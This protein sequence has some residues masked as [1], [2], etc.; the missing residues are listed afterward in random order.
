MR[1]LSLAAL[2]ALALSLPGY[3]ASALTLTLNTGGASNLFTR[4]NDGSGATVSETV[5]PVAVPYSY[6]STSVDGAA[7]AESGYDLS[8]NGFD[9]TFDHV[10]LATSGS[11]GY[12]SGTITFS[13]DQDVDY[14]ASGSYTA[15]DSEGRRIYFRAV[16][17]NVT[18]AYNEFNS[19]QV[20]ESTPNE[21]FTLG[22][23]EGDAGNTLTGSLTGTLVAGYDYAFYYT[24]FIDTVPAATTSGATAT[25]SL[26]LS[27]V[28]EPGAGLL[29]TTG[30]LGLA[31]ARRRRGAVSLE[32]PLTN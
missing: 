1:R 32:P 29:A 4:A 2:V 19:L 3:S 14:V 23:T 13:V 22:L 21:S 30:L 17:A 27:F 5:Y 12:S 20:S 31:I 25:G 7:S 8:I 11:Q 18:L 10:R 16:L 9:I 6:T 24:A 28:P 15:V 26:S